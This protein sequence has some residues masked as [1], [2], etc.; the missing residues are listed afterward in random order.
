MLAYEDAA[1][2]ADWLCRTFGFRERLRF[3]DASGV[4]TH[5]ELELGSGLVMLATP[6]PDYHGPRRHDA[7]CETARR[8]R[9]NPYVIDGVHVYVDDVDAHAAAAEAGGARILSRVEDQAHGDR[10]Y[11]VEDLEGHRWMFS[12]RIRAVPPEEWGAQAA[13][14]PR[15]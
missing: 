15:R 7:E 9:A 2:A 4:V 6:S 8:W 1:A 13:A 12:Q 14:A 5:A 11:R 10:N 3:T